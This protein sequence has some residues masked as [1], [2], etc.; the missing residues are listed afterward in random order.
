MYENH[1]HTWL[2]ALKFPR[3][4][5]SNRSCYQRAPATGGRAW[6]AGLRQVR[7]QPHPHW[8]TPANTTHKKHHPAQKKK[9]ERNNAKKITTDTHTSYT[10]VSSEL[11]A[12]TPRNPLRGQN[13]FEEKTKNSIPMGNRGFAY[14]HQIFSVAHYIVLQP[15]WTLHWHVKISLYHKKWQSNWYIIPKKLLSNWYSRKQVRCKQRILTK[16]QPAA[17]AFHLTH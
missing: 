13:K 15:F 2:P 17:L 12:T 8:W 11:H 5:F 3:N 4:Q 9:R 14:I 10:H 16:Q 7:R 1:E 6:P